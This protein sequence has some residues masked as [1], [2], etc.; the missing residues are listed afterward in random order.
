ML[1]V[2]FFSVYSGIRWAAVESSFPPQ[3]KQ[4]VTSDQIEQHLNENQTL[5]I[6]EGAC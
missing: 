5:Q 3:L 6:T 1:V 4:D 2:L